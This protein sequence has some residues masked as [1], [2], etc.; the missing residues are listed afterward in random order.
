MNLRE[1]FVFASAT[2]PQIITEAIQAMASATPPVYADELYI[3]ATAPAKKRALNKLLHEGI[4]NSLCLEWNIP[5]VPFSEESF[6][7][8]TGN[9]GEPLEDMISVEDNEAA[10]DKIAAFLS[11]MAAM[12]ST[13]LHCFLGGG[14]QTM[15]FYMGTA[16]QLVARQWDRMYHINVSLG[17]E[18]NDQFFYKPKLNKTLLATSSDGSKRRLNTRDAEIIL[19]ELPLIYL[20]E[21]LP[22]AKKTNSFRAM[23]SE[24]QKELDLAHIVLPI[25]LNLSERTLLL[26][27]QKAVLTP[28]QLMVYATF[29]R[30]KLDVCR[31]EKR[32][33]CEGCTACFVA[34][35]DLTSVE[36]VDA[37]ANDYRTLYDDDEFKKESL[38]EKWG[39][40][41]DVEYLRQQISKINGVIKKV[42]TDEYSLH[43]FQ[44]T[45]I[46]KYGGSRYGIKVDRARI[47]IVSG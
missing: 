24:S 41:L 34:L 36:A 39:R 32:G 44:I 7:E 13:R 9:N 1:V 14:R 29:L 10:G 43:V 4:L 40:N 45:A 31:T 3:I 33:H 16:F 19:N 21:K 8:L 25:T 5:M 46:R 28:L 30:Q 27:D 15:T 37:M 20:R 17:F 2:P 6:I 23:V 22:L 38:V 18:R 11:E 42:V 26:G 47:Q 12:P 35:V